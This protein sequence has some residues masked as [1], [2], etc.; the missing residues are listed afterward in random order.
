MKFGQ[1]MEYT[2]LLKNNTQNAVGKLLQD[3]DQK[4]SNLSIPLDQECKVLNSLFLL[5]AS[6]RAIK[7]YWT[8]AADHLFL[9]NL[10]LF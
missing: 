5:Y 9:P 3:P 2:F 1:L 7:I 10:K 8:L 4:K 6:L